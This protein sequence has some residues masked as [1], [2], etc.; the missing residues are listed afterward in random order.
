MNEELLNCL[1][2]NYERCPGRKFSFVLKDGRR[3]CGVIVSF[4]RNNGQLI[5]G[6]HVVDQQYAHGL[7][8]DLLGNSTGMLL[9]SK[10]IVN[11]IVEPSFVGLDCCDLRQDVN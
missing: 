2:K 11:F 1:F 10:D 9:A 8:S 6:W 4:C 7:G 5:S 3:I